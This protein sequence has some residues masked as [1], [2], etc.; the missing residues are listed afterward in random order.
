MNTQLI[1]RVEELKTERNSA[2]QDSEDLINGM[3]VKKQ[4]IQLSFSWVTWYWLLNNAQKICVE[5]AVH[6]LLKRRE[7]FLTP[8]YNIKMLLQQ[9]KEAFEEEMERELEQE[10][11]SFKREKQLLQVWIWNACFIWFFLSFYFCF[12][13]LVIESDSLSC[14]IYTAEDRGKYYEMFVLSFYLMY[15]RSWHTELSKYDR[16]HGITSPYI[17]FS[18]QNLRYLPTVNFSLFRH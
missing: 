1:Q 13:S 3:Q 9:L 18:F 15:S 2:L 16:F 11:A 8:T 14:F 10:R 12:S 5:P 7:T 6:T 4:L 17:Y